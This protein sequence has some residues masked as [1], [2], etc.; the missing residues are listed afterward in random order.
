MQVF[1]EV[2]DYLT[3]V[4]EQIRWKGAR[5]V[6]AQ[7]LEDHI[8]DQAE[9]FVEAGADVSSATQKAIREMGDPVVTGQRL[10][11][12]HRPK[13]DIVM[14]VLV[15]LLIL[16]GGLVQYLLSLAEPS[17]TG[18]LLSHYCRY[19]LMGV[20]AFAAIFFVDF[21]I[22]GRRPMVIFA[23]LLVIGAGI[24]LFAQPNPTA[25]VTGFSVALLFVPAFAG[26]IF[27][28]R[29][30][31]YRGLLICCLFFVSAAAVCLYLLALGGLILLTLAC[32]VLLAATIGRGWFC[33]KKWIAI[34]SVFL[35]PVLVVALIPGVGRRLFMAVA[36]QLD[37]THHGYM[38]FMLRQILSGAQLWGPAELS[39]TL[40]GQ[41]VEHLLP[42]WN[43][44]FVLTYLMARYGIL[45]GALLVGLLVLLIVKLFRAAFR[46]KSALGFIVFLSVAMAFAAQSMIY[47]LNNVGVFLFSSLLPFLSSGG[48]GFVVNMVLLGMAFSA[49]RRNDIIRDSTLSKKRAQ[50]WHLSYTG[51]K[52]WLKKWL[53]AMNRNEA[54]D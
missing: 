44:D 32:S 36:P 54:S 45:V 22:L 5:D 40:S 39:G 47:I 28:Q 8:Q 20:S 17:Y 7:E 11:R 27:S 14:L 38:G 49:V 35:L 2:K 41:P 9:A 16:F 37:P 1:T 51:K 30:K 34:P 42:T 6:V 19:A 26:I 31:G 25:R 3:A 33:V 23:L 50:V 52:K 21:S 13:T 43:T 29:G 46:Q 48:T 53:G 15:S 4:C 12:L 10:D 18:D 24:G